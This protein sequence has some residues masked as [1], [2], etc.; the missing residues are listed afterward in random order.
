[1]T[2]K[3]E[4]NYRLAGG[5]TV[6]DADLEAD[7][8]RFEAGECDGAWKVLPGHPTLSGLE[9]GQCAVRELVDRVHVGQD[10]AIMRHHDGALVL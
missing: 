9:P 7:A 2:T 5:I 8:Q 3:P 10:R 4:E 6:T 1:M